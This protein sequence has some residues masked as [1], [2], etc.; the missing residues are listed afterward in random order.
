MNLPWFSSKKANKEGKDRHQVM[1]DYYQG[2]LEE[3]ER[4]DILAESTLKDALDEAEE[5][6]DLYSDSSTSR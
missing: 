3:K 5:W 2:A 4:Q 1:R 6:A